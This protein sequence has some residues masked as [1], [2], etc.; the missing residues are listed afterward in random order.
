MQKVE[1]NFACSSQILLTSPMSNPFSGVSAFT[2]KLGVETMI[3]FTPVRCC[4]SSMASFMGDMCTWPMM[5]SM[6][7][8]KKTSMISAMASRLRMCS[9]M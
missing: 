9:L 3:A 2:G 5:V 8:R 1:P 4:A 6:P 7:A